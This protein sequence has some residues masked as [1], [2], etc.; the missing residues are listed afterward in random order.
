VRVDGVRGVGTP[1]ELC[2]RAV[3]AEVWPD[4]AVALRCRQLLLEAKYE[5]NT[6]DTAE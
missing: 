3:L 1:L 4:A 6:L 2:Y 5:G